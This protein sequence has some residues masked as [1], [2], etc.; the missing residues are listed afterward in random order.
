VIKK[1]DGR[2]VW[3]RPAVEIHNLCRGM[4]PWPGGQCTL[5][6]ER[7][8]VVRTRVT[9]LESTGNAGSILKIE[10]DELFVSTGN[11]V[12]SILEL[13]PEGKNVMTGAAFAR[14]RRLAEGMG[15]EHQ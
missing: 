12:L 14:G 5:S 15:F 13:K 11:G 8:T 4:Y 9:D 7:I 3:S 2:I 6:G 10:R 1:D